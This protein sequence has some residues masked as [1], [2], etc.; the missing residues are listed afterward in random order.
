MKSKPIYRLFLPLLMMGAAA[1]QAHP[2]HEHAHWSSPLVHALF[3]LA[4]LAAAGTGVYLLRRRAS[5]RKLAKKGDR[6]Q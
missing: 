6:T 2:G 4:I 1:A 3:Y 5:S